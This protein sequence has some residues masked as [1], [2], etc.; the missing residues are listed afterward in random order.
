M[1]MKNNQGLLLVEALI[2][3]AVVMVLSAVAIPKVMN[4]AKKVNTKQEM[5]Y[6]TSVIQFYEAD[7]GHLPHSLN[8]LHSY[9]NHNGYKKDAWS[10]NYQYKKWVRELCSTT[11]NYC[12]DF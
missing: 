10:N 2:Y 3:L 6:I 12:K 8:N 11:I 1:N 5:Q 4:M 7:K 9:F